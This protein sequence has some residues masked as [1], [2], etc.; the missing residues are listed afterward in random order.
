MKTL[1]SCAPT[2]FNR[3]LSERDIQL[4]KRWIEQGAQWEEHWSFKPI[5]KSPLPTL[6]ENTST[7]VRNE[8]DLFIQKKLQGSSLSPAEE[9]S[10][11]TLIRRLYLD[12]TGLPPTREELQEYLDDTSP[13]AYEKLVDR[14]LESKHF[15]QRMAWDW[16]DAARY[17]DTNGYQGD[18]ERTMWPWRDWVVKAFNDNLHTTNSPVGNLLVSVAQFH[19]RAKTRD[20]IQ[21]QSYDQRRGGRIAEKSRRICHG[22]DGNHGDDMVRND[23]ELL[24]LP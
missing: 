3:E 5:K 16:L 22:H 15:G 12:L 8:I 24:P 23:A 1:R 4:I 14:V 7:P 9:A 17:A 13:D 6:S 18:R 19:A 10:R 2:G 20:G 11:Q 21:S